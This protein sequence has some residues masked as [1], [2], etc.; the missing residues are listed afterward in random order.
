MY[1]Y[2]CPFYRPD[3]QPIL[4]YVAPQTVSAY[5]GQTVMTSIP[6]YGRVRAFIL[7]F[8]P[9]T[10]MA[11]LLIATPYGGQQ[12]LE[13]HYSDMVGISPVIAG[14]GGGGGAG[15]GPGGGFG[16][17][18]GGGFGGGGPGGFSGFGS[19]GGSGGGTGF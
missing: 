16:G 5:V 13:V 14:G 7:S 17:G 9:N 19:G 6:G 15:V 11:Q 3:G 12:Y 2:N 4:Q 1:R 8:N 18:L 10:G